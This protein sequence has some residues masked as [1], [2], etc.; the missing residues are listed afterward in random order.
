MDLLVLASGTVINVLLVSFIARR[1]LGAPVGWPR[2]IITSLIVTYSM[3]AVLDSTA[4]T[5]GLDP[6]VADGPSVL[7]YLLVIAWMIAAQVA[8]LALLEVLVPTGSLPGPLGLL[9]SL[10]S[11]RRRAG[12]YAA[13]LRIAT[14]HGL[15]A[16]LR[17][18]RRAPDESASR[19]ARSLRLA[20]TDGGV[21]FVKLGQMISSRPD[22]VP[23]AFIDELSLLQ[24]KVPGAPWAQVEPVIVEELGRPLDEVFASI[25]HEPLAAASVA[26]IHRARLLSGEQVVVKVQRPDARTQTMA[27]LDIVLRLADRLDRSTDWGRR[28]GVKDL[29]QG[30]ADS[31]EEELDYRRELA[32][33]K[34]IRAA[35]AG[36]NRPRV[37]IPTVHEQWCTSRVMVMD[38]MPGVPVSDAGELLAALPAA[39]RRQMADDLLAVVLHQVVVAGVFHADLHPGNIFVQDGGGLGLLDFGSVGRLDAGARTSVGL[40]LAAVDRADSMAA[41]DALLELLD[42]GTELDDRRLERDVGQL[43]VRFAASGG[44]G[45]DGASVGGGTAEL[46]TEL[47]RVV[48]DHGLSVPP[49]V[50]AAFRALGALEGS[51]TVISP[52]IDLVDAARDQG[53]ELVQSRMTPEA[54][55]EALQT[56]LAT[57]LPLLQRLPRRIDKISD[58]LEQG[59][60]RF[61]IRLLGDPDDRR[62]ITGI[63]HQFVVTVLATACTLGGIIL[64]AADSGPLMAKEFRLYAFIGFTLLLFG[65]VLAARVLVGVFQYR[66]R[67]R[68]D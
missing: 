37:Q 59:R 11:R 57:M 62:F 17:R 24:S 27:D 61:G 6:S 25:E 41:T 54:A 3:G 29:A 40:L 16:Y 19:V 10:P 20:L 14:K 46:F 67:S 58:D 43:I 52:G 34:A 45:S 60:L 36:A 65:F 49:Q 13:I 31:L 18:G 66:P 15:G 1:L 68:A 55:K 21:T 50:A 28:L 23:P 12:R 8:L 42:R 39:E 44:P 63:V 9:R 32:N 47:F 26:Q 56:Q 53:R 64:I 2:T 48:L 5:L 51:L 35:T 7:I 30:F 22:L 33:L 4:K 38:V